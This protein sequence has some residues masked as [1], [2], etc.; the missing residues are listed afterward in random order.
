MNKKT[1]I[2]IVIFLICFAVAVTVLQVPQAKVFIGLEGKNIGAT[3]KPG[4]M[5]LHPSG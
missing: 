1:K 4:S 5:N 2:V 3:L